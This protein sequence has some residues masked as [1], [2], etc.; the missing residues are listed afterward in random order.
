MLLDLVVS[1]Y[2]VHFYGAQEV[3]PLCA[4][5]LTFSTPTFVLAKASLAAGVGFLLKD[6]SWWAKVVTVAYGVAVAWD[7][8]ILVLLSLGVNRWTTPGP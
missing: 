7:L 1:V 5:L 4:A 6:E 2:A 8:A 3:N